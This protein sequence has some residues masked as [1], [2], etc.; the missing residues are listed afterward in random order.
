MKKEEANRGSGTRNSLAETLQSSTRVPRGDGL[1]FG[2]KA[3]KAFPETL[4]K[5][6]GFRPCRSVGLG[7]TLSKGQPH[8][9]VPISRGSCPSHGINNVEK[10]VGSGLSGSWEEGQGGGSGYSLRSL[11][12]PR[13]VPGWLL[14]MES[15]SRGSGEEPL[16]RFRL[17]TRE[18]FLMG[19]WVWLWV[20]TPS[21]LGAHFPSASL[22]DCPSTLL[23][24]F[25]PSIPHLSPTCPSVLHFLSLSPF[26]PSLLPSG[27]YNTHSRVPA[28]CLALPW[29]LRQDT[30]MPGGDCL[31]AHGT[32]DE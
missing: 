14:R 19:F 22:N 30:E 13:W 16:L 8:L 15:G 24:S 9:P 5:L 3:P 27:A 32:F 23:P 28:S 29:P 4:P 21:P 10:E 17:G 26:L 25:H 18:P 7:C 6:L 12:R 31:Q 2:G 11:G 20:D 1:R